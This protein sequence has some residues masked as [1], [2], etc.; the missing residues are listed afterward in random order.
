M[1]EFENTERN[2]IMDIE[3]ALTIEP[4]KS[5]LDLDNASKFKKLSLN[6]QQLAQVSELTRYLPAA[7][8][9]A[10][11]ATQDIY[12]M[13]IPKGLQYTLAEFRKYPGYMNT[14]RN[15]EGRFVK[16]GVLQ[17][18]TG[19]PAVL[20]AFTTVAAVSGQYFLAEI[21]SEM[22]MMKQG[23]DDIMEFLNDEKQSE[24]LA[25]VS[26]VKYALQNYNSII[27]CDAQRIATI[28]GLQSAKK[29]ANK[30]VEFYTRALDSSLADND[31]FKSVDSAAKAKDS[32]DLSMQLSAMSTLLEVYYSQNFDP[33]YLSWIEDS[34]TRYIMNHNSKVN[35]IFNRLTG[36][37]DN[38][39]NGFLRKDDRRAEYHNKLLKLL[40]TV[41]TSDEPALCGTLRSGLRVITDETKLYFTKDSDVY[42]SIV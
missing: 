9:T 1:P 16:Q 31:V 12:V 21:N 42:L 17:K 33:G 10:M 6:R 4:S 14:F 30:N 20:G 28:A 3:D 8:A 37:L 13:T 36:R 15:E 7:A 34:E 41:N 38:R 2:I 5:V 25:E 40:E 29:I 32:L 35:D 24:L 27:Q 23:I 19:S 22:R 26:F 18:V 11:S 39:G